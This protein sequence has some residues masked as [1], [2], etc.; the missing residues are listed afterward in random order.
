MKRLKKDNR[1]FTLAELLI[2]IAIMAIVLAPLFHNFIVST[3]LNRKAKLAMNATNMA[4]NIMEGFNAYT[5]EQLIIGFDSADGRGNMAIFPDDITCNSHGEAILNGDGS[6]SLGY[7][8]TGNAASGGTANYV[9]GSGVSANSLTM[10]P[11]SNSKYYFFAEGVKQ[12]KTY[13]DMLVIMD[14]SSASTFSG[15]SNEN[16]IIEGGERELYNDYGS[17]KIAT[18]N[19]LVDSVYRD[20][21]TV[22]SDAYAMYEPYKQQWRECS[23][24]TFY[25]Q[26]TRKIV[27]DIGCTKDGSG[28]ITATEVKVHNDFH[29]KE[30]PWYPPYD[31][32]ELSTPYDVIYHSDTQYPRDIYIYYYPNYYS[33]WLAGNN[34]FDEFEINNTLERDVTVHLIRL[35]IAGDPDIATH[36]ASYRTSITLNEHSSDGLIHTKIISNLK[37]DLTKSAEDNAANRLSPDRCRFILNGTAL[38][39][40]DAQY[41]SIVTENG[42]I[43]TEVSDRLYSVVVEVYEE[44]AAA[45]GFPQEMRVAV[46]DGSAKK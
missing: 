45:L 28:V 21:S 32:A 6:W 36:E 46:Y 39:V 1:G 40:S 18:M 13:Y 20:N 33:T 10:V 8:V 3:N 2:A 14:A 37:D 23:E 16:G 15:D 24:D 7:T 31:P 4:S 43:S 27:I 22:W 34:A 25:K 29:C 9:S 26:T 38:D 17:I 12:N 19:G 35:P 30:N 41:K 5:A 44:G 42:G 11:S